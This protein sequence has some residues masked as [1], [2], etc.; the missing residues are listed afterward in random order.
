MGLLDLTDLP[1]PLPSSSISY[2]VM[3]HNKATKIVYQSQS[4]CWNSV[5]TLVN[6]IQG[7]PWT[8][9]QALPLSYSISLVITALALLSLVPDVDGNPKQ[10]WPSVSDGLYE[11]V[12]ETPISLV[13]LRLYSLCFKEEWTVLFLS[14]SASVALRLIPSVPTPHSSMSQ[15]KMGYFI[16]YLKVFPSQAIQ[17]QSNSWSL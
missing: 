5:V 13:R 12:Y 6:I 17:R 2:L 16:P 1:E 11:P 15:T 8:E 10:W 9:D 14:F 4:S 7:G 3:R